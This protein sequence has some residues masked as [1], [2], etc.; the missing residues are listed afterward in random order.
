MQ[1]ELKAVIHELEQ[2]QT[3]ASIP[4]WHGREVV[5][6]QHSD[7]R[8]YQLERVRWGKPTCKCM[9]KKAQLHGRYWYAYWRENGKLKSRYVGK[10]L[11]LSKT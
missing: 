9:G 2:Q 6:I 10:K 11:D 3:P 5:R 1:G 7:N 8:L 4:P